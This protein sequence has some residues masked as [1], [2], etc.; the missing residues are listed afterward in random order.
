MDEFKGKLGNYKII[1]TDDL[2]E[3][4][5]S[6]FFDEACHN[7]S[8]A[9]EETYHNYILGCHLPELFTLFNT[10]HILD[11]GFGVGMGLSC[12]IE[13]METHLYHS[14]I[15]HY[16]SIELDDIF[17]LWSLA[18]F[19]PDVCLEKVVSENNSYLKGK[20]KNFYIKI[21]L[22]DGRITLPDAY[23]KKI[24]PN[25]N[26]IF[27]DPF[28]PKKNP[29]LW[30]VEWF[31]FLKNSS[32]STVRLATYS[33]SVS[34]RKS[35]VAAGW[36]IENHKGFGNKKSMTQAGL[37]GTIENSLLDQLARSPA[38]E[39]HDLELRRI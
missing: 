7:L 27:Q 39:L 20:Y 31:L 19:L 35:M 16:T 13:F 9:K 14:H 22:G 5:W 15:V 18:K 30:T 21:F 12:L 8:G 6:E 17:A 1:K 11:V 23:E 36:V 38:V 34:I 33:A 29:T 3:T 24:I 25:F 2:T 37:E 32:F 10:V 26:I 28:S 4:V